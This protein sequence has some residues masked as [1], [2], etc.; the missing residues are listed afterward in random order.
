MKQKSCLS[1]LFAII[2]VL[3]LLSPTM[4][5]DTSVPMQGSELKL[6]DSCDDFQGMFFVKDGQQRV[7]ADDWDQRDLRDLS[8]RLNGRNMHNFT[9]GWGRQDNARCQAIGFE[10]NAGPY[11]CVENST[12]LHGPTIPSQIQ[13][14]QEAE[15]VL[16]NKG[17]PT[18]PKPVFIRDPRLKQP[19]YSNVVIA[20][21]P[22][23]NPIFWRFRMLVFT[24][25]EWWMPRNSSIEVFYDFTLPISQPHYIEAAKQHSPPVPS[26]SAVVSAFLDMLR[27]AECIIATAECI[28]QE[29]Q[30]VLDHKDDAIEYLHE[31]Q[32]Q[33]QEA[34]RSL[35]ERLRKIEIQMTTD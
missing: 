13:T 15:V 25:A 9:C 32:Q 2:A 14:R 5:D 21:Y 11:T 26:D 29:Q 23:N 31:L 12:I 7:G 3:G 6:F 27:P 28:A 20:K 33:G 4:A 34:G 10:G 19:E 24:P 35:Q 8:L 17:L 1:S 18:M 16:L 30:R 22:D